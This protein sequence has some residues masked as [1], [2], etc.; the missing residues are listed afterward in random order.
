MTTDAADIKWVMKEY[1]EKSYPNEF[2]NLN[3]H[4]PWRTI[5]KNDKGGNR[6][7]KQLHIY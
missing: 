2:N 4:I 3:G 6:K 5:S 7:P 1:Y